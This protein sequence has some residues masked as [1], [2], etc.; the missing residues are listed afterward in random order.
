[1]LPI[2]RQTLS[3]GLLAPIDNGKV[4]LISAIPAHLSGQE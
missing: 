2:F 3:P 1:M 4:T